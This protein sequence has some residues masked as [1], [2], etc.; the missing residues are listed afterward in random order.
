MELNGEF[1]ELSCLES[2]MQTKSSA[3]TGGGGVTFSVCHGGANDVAI[4]YLIHG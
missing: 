4:L 1:P 2:V 3:Y